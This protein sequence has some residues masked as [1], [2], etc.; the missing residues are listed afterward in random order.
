M[1]SQKTTLS[2]P[3]LALPGGEGTQYSNWYWMAN[4]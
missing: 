4:K 1:L 3:T 2:G